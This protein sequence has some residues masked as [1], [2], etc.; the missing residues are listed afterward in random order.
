MNYRLTIIP[1]MEV[2]FNPI[3]FKFSSYKELLAAAN[4][5]ADLLLFIQDETKVMKDYSNLFTCEQVVNGE[6]LEIED[7]EA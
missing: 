1:A 4:S 6:W 5:C 2:S 7:N 3:Q